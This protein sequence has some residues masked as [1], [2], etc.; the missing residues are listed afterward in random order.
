M[1]EPQRNEN[2]EP[3]RIGLTEKTDRQLEELLDHLNDQARSEQ[4]LIKFDIYRLAVAL[5]IK[6]GE[7]PKP[8]SGNTDKAF[9]VTELDPDKALFYAVKESKLCPSQQSIYHAVECL[10]D[11][12]IQL[13]YNHYLQNTENFF[14]EELI[15]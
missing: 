7:S 14:W 2:D 12:G 15:T 11:H 3:K 1:N 4:V 13:I 10:A 5:G 6:K 9:R 8:I